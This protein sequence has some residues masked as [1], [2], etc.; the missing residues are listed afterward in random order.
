MFELVGVV[1]LGNLEV[2]IEYVVFNGVCVIE[3]KIVVCGFGII[4]EVVMIDF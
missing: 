3:V 2:L 4:W 1:S